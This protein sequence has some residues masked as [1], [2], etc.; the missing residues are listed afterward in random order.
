MFIVEKSSKN[1]SLKIKKNDYN[2]T[3]H[4]VKKLVGD[5]LFHNFRLNN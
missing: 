4:H 2:Y 3:L 1:S 5:F